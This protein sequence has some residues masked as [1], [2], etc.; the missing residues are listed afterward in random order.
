MK[1]KG[2]L[3]AFSLSSM[4]A[5]AAVAAPLHLPDQSSGGIGTYTSPLAALDAPDDASIGNGPYLIT[6]FMDRGTPELR[7]QV[8]PLFAFVKEHPTYKVVIKELPLL[9]QESLDI[10]TAETAVTLQEDEAIWRRFE[11]RLISDKSPHLTPQTLKAYALWAGVKEDAYDKAISSGQVMTKLA[12]NRK[13]AESAGIHSVPYFVFLPTSVED[14]GET[15]AG[16]MS[17]EKMD[18]IVQKHLA[19]SKDTTINK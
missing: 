3:A 12:F 14:N 19:Q 2:F 7:K 18:E 13:M 1:F 15:V 5:S 4:L 16:Q 6:V 11:Y 10:A 9:S 17:A 8:I